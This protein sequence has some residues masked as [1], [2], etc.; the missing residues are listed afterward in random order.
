MSFLLTIRSKP[1]LKWLIVSCCTFFGLQMFLVAQNSL[2]SGVM[3]LGVTYAAILNT[4][5]FG[6]VPLMLF[7]FNK[8]RKQKGERFMYQVCAISFAIGM[9]SFCLA[10]Q[11][12]WGD[13]IVPKLIIGSIGA[14]IGSIGTAGFFMMPYLVPTA[15]ASIEEKII[16][17]CV[18]WD[19]STIYQSRISASERCERTVLVYNS[20]WQ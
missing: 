4:F 9:L 15:I 11:Y 12:I 16:L 13:N 10:G 2:I 7:L 18:I 19:N 1:F 17:E 3:N 6:P 14:V 5:A 20:V 8:V